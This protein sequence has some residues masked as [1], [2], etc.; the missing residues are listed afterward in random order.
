MFHCF[1]N[2]SKGILEAASSI[3]NNNNSQYPQ[4]VGTILKFAYIFKS[5]L[6]MVPFLD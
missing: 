2:R 5:V 6:C 4:Y 1:L 3:G